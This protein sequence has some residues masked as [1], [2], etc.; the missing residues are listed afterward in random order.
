MATVTET[1][2]GTVRVFLLDDHEV[3]RRGVADLLEAEPDL[4]VVGEAATAAEALARVPAVRPD[5]AVLDVRLPDG[6]G[7]TVCRE[8]RSLFPDLRCLM[9]TSF[10]DDDALFDAIMAGASGYVLKQIRGTDLVGAVR[11]V[12][13][14]QSLLDPRTTAKVLERMRA[15][16]ED[17]GPVAGLSEQER[18]VLALIGEGLTNREIGERMFLAEKTVKNYVSHLLAKLGMQRRT[19]AAILATELRRSGD[20][21]P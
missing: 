13:S 4:T 14:G 3:V 11:T 12:A 15:A 16:A 5:V 1:A 18:T 20:L 10:A 6:D 7:V 2:A 17:K 21:E 8:L 9:L 19:Q